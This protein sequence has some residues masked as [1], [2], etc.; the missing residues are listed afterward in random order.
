MS[1]RPVAVLA[2][3]VGAARFLRGLVRVVAPE[4]ITVIG[5]TGDA[6]LSDGTAGRRRAP[7]SRHGRA[8]GAAGRVEPDPS[9]ERCADRDAPADRRRR[10][11]FPGVLR[12]RALAAGGSRDLLDRAR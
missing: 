2:G 3:G 1:A 7:P 12:A 6:P 11:A 10:P 9:D 8:R 5:N 4:D